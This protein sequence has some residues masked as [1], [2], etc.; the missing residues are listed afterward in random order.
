MIILG[1]EPQT[2]RDDQIGFKRGVVS[3]N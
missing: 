3:S 2:I 1:T